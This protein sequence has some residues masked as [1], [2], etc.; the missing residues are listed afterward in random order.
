MMN[1]FELIDKYFENNL[2]PK[3]QRIFNEL[4]NNNEDFKEEFLFQKDLKKIIALDQRENLKSTLQGFEN[5][6]EKEVKILFLPKKWFAA[7]SIILLLG[8][9]TWFVN[10]TYFPSNQKIYATNFVAYRNII[11]P[12]V[13]SSEVNTIEYKAFVAYENRECHKALNL[14][15]STVNSKEEYIQFYKAMC[16]LSLS[17]PSNAI[18]LL[19]PIATSTNKNDSKINFKEIAN[20]YLALAYLKNEEKQKAISQFSFIANHPDNYFKKEEANKI[21]NY[22]N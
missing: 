4:L 14:F 11:Q 12:V 13:R 18:N 20:W 16:Y 9:G 2:T 7:A 6:I 19:L 17:K 3:E 15:N 22:L 1:D 10:D 21:L 8:L 5:K